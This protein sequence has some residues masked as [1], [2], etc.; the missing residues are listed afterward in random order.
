ML[1]RQLYNSDWA[2]M[3]E[4]DQLAYASTDYEGKTIVSDV[5]V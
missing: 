4:D 2:Q 3:V 5:G 1:I